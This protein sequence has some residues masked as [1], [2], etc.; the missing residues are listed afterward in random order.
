[1]AE[2]TKRGDGGTGLASTYGARAVATY[3]AKNALLYDTGY[4]SINLYLV[5]ETWGGG[6]VCPV[7]DAVRYHD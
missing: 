4:T 7:P 3:D 6:V 2:A 5:D 1:M